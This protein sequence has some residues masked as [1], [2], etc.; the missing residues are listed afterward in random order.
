MRTLI[1]L[2][3]IIFLL[4]GCYTQFVTMESAL[5][6]NEPVTMVDS[7]TGDT[8]KVIREVDTIVSREKETCVW[9]RDMFGNPHLQCYDSYYSRSWLFYNNTPWWYR[10]DPYWY[11]YN[12]CPR[13]YNYDPSCG[14]CRYYDNFHHRSHGYNSGNRY[15]NNQYHSGGSPHTGSSGTSSN[16]SGQKSSPSGAP[17]T[18]SSSRTSAQK[19]PPP[20]VQQQPSGGG[21]VQKTSP[22]SQQ[23]SPPPGN[24]DQGTTKQRNIRSTRSR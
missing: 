6:S 16:S 19:A 7:A 24:S 14:C 18:G 13:Y 2:S 15:Y 17:I 12:R 20:P 11:D 23:Q 4:P 1:L 8:I 22:P 3:V 10:N 9:V 5:P 21:S